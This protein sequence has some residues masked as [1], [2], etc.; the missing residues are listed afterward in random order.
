MIIHYAIC[1]L[2]ATKARELKKNVILMRD[3]SIVIFHY[4]I[5]LYATKAR[6]LKKKVILMRELINSDFPLCNL[7][8]IC[9]KGQETKKYL[10]TCV[11]CCFLLLPRL[12]CHVYTCAF[13]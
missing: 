10:I 9:H 11:P 3:E 7:Y 8:A 13:P 5:N 2:Y 1:T 12:Q 6:E 4:A